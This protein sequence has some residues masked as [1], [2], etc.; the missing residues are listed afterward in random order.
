MG[1]Q[2]GLQTIVGLGLVPPTDEVG[3]EGAACSGWEQGNTGR[4]EAK[5]G[6]QSAVGRVLFWGCHGFAF[7]VCNS[8]GCL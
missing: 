4:V 1:L 6:K 8:L 3:D 5:L 7:I 2:D